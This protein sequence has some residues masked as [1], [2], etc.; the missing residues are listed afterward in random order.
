MVGRQASRGTS[1][2]EMVPVIKRG[3]GKGEGSGE[4]AC[5]QSMIKDSKAIEVGFLTSAFPGVTWERND[6]LIVAV[7]RV[8]TCGL[9]KALPISVSAEMFLSYTEDLL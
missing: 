3:K 7:R 4:M 1:E 8:S 2:K 6:I 5:I 9:H